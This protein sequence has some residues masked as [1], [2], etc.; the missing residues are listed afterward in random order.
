MTA[1]WRVGTLVWGGVLEEREGTDWVADYVAALAL[2]HRLPVYCDATPTNLNVAS[3]IARRH[4][5]VQV[6]TLSSVEFASAC[7][8]LHTEVMA[9]TFR[10]TAQKDLDDA[11]AVA[12][13]RPLGDGGWAWGRRVSTGYIHPLVSVSVGLKGFDMLPAQRITRVLTATPV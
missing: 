1:S 7:S 3:Q 2:K 10:H 6:H 5:K 9:A 11:V 8:L 4:P 12:A 13:K